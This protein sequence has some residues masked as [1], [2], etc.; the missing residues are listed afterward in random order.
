MS[1][2]SG[3]RRAPALQ[4]GLMAGLVLLA[5]ALTARPAHAAPQ[6]L[7]GFWVNADNTASGYTL[8]NS[9]DG[10]V[11]TADWAGLP[12][13]QTLKGHFQGELD[14]AADAYDGRFN[15]KEAPAVSVSGN[16][17]FQLRSSLFA[18]FPKIDVFLTPDNG[19]QSEFT[20]EIF[21]A[22]PLLR[23]DGVTEEVTDPGTKPASGWVDFGDVTATNGRVD[24]G[25]IVRP[26]ATKKTT[27]GRT[28]FKLKPGKSRRISVSLNAKGRKLLKKR[29]SLRVLVRVH[30]NKSS[31]LPPLTKA[32]V[33][34]FKR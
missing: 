23:P 32:G 14:V 8:R 10:S 31:G 1:W 6:N 20:L 3:L 16:G 15:V 2:A 7:S 29:G 33:V 17:T 30:M 9:T 21:S 11:L 19:Q 24:A 13:H 5:L 25:S 4:L 28:N 34:T 26:A 27:L 18:G 12:P 22:L